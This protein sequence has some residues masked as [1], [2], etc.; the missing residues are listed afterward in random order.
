MAPKWPITK[1]LPVLFSKFDPCLR[2][3]KVIQPGRKPI[4]SST[5]AQQKNRTSPP[6]HRPTRPPKAM[7]E[8]DYYA[9][10]NVTPNSTDDEIKRSHKK[11]RLHF[12]EDKIRQRI[13]RMA[14]DNESKMKHGH[15]SNGDADY[16]KSLKKSFHEEWVKIDRAFHILSSPILRPIYD[17]FGHEGLEFAEQIDKRSR[18]KTS[19]NASSSS[20]SSSSTS[21]SSSSEVG[22]HTPASIRV[23]QSV[24]EA[25]RTRNQND[26]GA[27][28]SS[29]ST[30]QMDINVD[31]L[32]DRGDDEEAVSFSSL[33]DLLDVPQLVL[34]TAV[35]GRPSD[36]DH[37]RKMCSP[38]NY[39]CY[40]YFILKFFFFER[41]FFLTHNN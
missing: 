1:V 34:Q 36:L 37:V 26:L 16:W 3:P 22:F 13:E 8:P 4:I 20:S 25:I 19:P 30:V 10:L 33:M 32:L 2:R 14:K 6:L 27:R 24:R 40:R 31:H 23:M 41:T 39:F 21:P 28:L 15:A 5:N 9:I 12:H 35:T 7:A 17:E 29:Q 11:L 18:K 38:K